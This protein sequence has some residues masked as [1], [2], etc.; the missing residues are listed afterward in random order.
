MASYMFSTVFEGGALVVGGVAMLIVA[1]V[2]IAAAQ[3][4]PK[5]QERQ[6][7]I[8]LAATKLGL[9]G[10]QLSDALKQARKDLGANQDR[11]RAK[12]LAKDEL[13]VAA[14]ALGLP[15]AKSLRQELRGSSL[16]AVAQKHNVPVTT[17]AG[18]IKTDVDAKI[19]ALVS[20]GTL[21]ADRAAT[22]TQKA[23]AR[24]DRLMTK[25]FNTAAP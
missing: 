3:S 20:A 2:G 11:P 17:V 10:E 8:N 9:T 23:N 19:Q 7:V 24:V 13:A 14:K 21:K 15:D 22:L 12:D 25:E 16:T 1:T 4:A 18:A 6:A 5:A